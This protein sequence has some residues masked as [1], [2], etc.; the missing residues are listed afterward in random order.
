MN[1]MRKYLVLFFLL[2]VSN[3]RSAAQQT[4][5]IIPPSPDAAALGVYGS[6]P[7]STYTGV[8]N[9]NIPL[10][11][12]NY[13]D[14]HI[15]IDLSYHAAGITVEQDASWVGLGWTL[16]VGGVI[17][18]TVRGGDD[19][20]LAADNYSNL[21]MPYQGFPY[22]NQN[23]SAGGFLESVCNGN[24][25]T[26]PDMFYFNFLGRSGSFVLENGQNSS[27]GSIA[28]TPLKAE[29]IDISYDKVNLRWQIRTDDGYTFYFGTVE[30]TET[31]HG[32]GTYGAGPESVQFD[33]IN[34]GFLTFDDVVVSAWYLDKIVSP[35]GEEVN[36]I[37]DSKVN[38]ARSYYYG[39]ARLS[40][41]DTKQTIVNDN[42]GQTSPCYVPNVQTSATKTFT[43]HAYLK[44][45]TFPLGKIVFNKSLRDD[46]IP[47]TVHSGSYQYILQASSWMSF[48]QYGPQKLDNIEV[49]NNDGMVIKTFE[50]SYNYFNSQV[51]DEERYKFRRLKL[52]KVRECSGLDCNPYYQL[53][54]DESHPL[55]SKY[56]TAQ[57]FWGYYNG[58]TNNNSRIPFGTFYNGMDNKYYFLGEADRQPNS[59]YMTSGTLNKIVYPTGGSSQFEFEPHDYNHFSNDAFKSTDFTNNTTVGITGLITAEY[60]SESYKT[61]SFTLTEATQEVIIDG[62]MTY[63]A[64]A[65]TSDPCNVV[66]PGTIYVGNEPWYS[67]Q[68]TS[69]SAIIVTR[70]M[71]EFL[72]FFVSNY[73]NNCLQPPYTPDAIDPIYRNKQTFILGAGT[74]ELKLYRR[75]GFNLNVTVNKNAMPSRII[76]QNTNGI[77]GKTAGGLRIKQIITRDNLT[78]VPQVKKYDYTVP[79]QNGQKYSTGRLLLFPNY[80]VPFY[81]TTEANVLVS[82]MGRSWDNVP[83]GTS[84]SGSVVG[85]D[86]VTESMGVNGEA[87]RTEYYYQNQIEE[88]S[89]FYTYIEGF[90][91]IKKTSNG[92]IQDIKHF[93]N[94]GNPVKTENYEYSKQLQKD[95]KGLATKHLL[96]LM[97]AEGGLIP[98]DRCTNRNMVS[99]AYTIISDRWV[100]IKKTEKLYSQN[101]TNFVQTVTD[102]EYDTQTHL[103]LKSEQS[104]TS[105]GEA[106]KTVYSY[107][108]DASWIPA[109]MWQDKFVYNKVVKKE[110]L[111]NNNISS[112]YKASYSSQANTFL[113]NKEET[114]IKTFPLE[115]ANTYNYS[116]NGNVQEMISRNG[117]TQTYLWDF[118]ASL[119]IAKVTASFAN[120]AYTSFEANGNGNWTFAGVPEIDPTAPTGKK[121]YDLSGGDVIK[122]ITNTTSYIIS[123]WRPINA[124]PLSIAGTQA[125]YPVTGRTVN[126]WKYYEH[127]VNNQTAVSLSGAGLIDELRLYPLNAQMTTYTYEPLIGMTSQCDANNVITYY[128]YDA[129]GRLTLIRDQD[130]NVIRTVDYKYQNN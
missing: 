55:P 73:E 79:G 124:S 66:D 54:Y 57:D 12:I 118:N 39:S 125:G 77:Y 95:I 100:P 96:M 11:S 37:Y 34:K 104:T 80:H 27:I 17:T 111:R 46:M 8:P 99:Q 70:S 114:A 84:A 76:T 71:S 113:L 74:Y 112:T 129:F 75:Q 97:R 52:D 109:A 30:I 69:T 119:P 35:L 116:S 23:E 78:T 92:L 9:I 89:Q 4:N 85:Y 122:S 107:P 93:D 90:P 121:V 5:T 21:F 86:K 102:Y 13:R 127:K 63:Y 53:F 44:E 81:C 64:S 42:L 20:Q 68:N 60:D 47:A 117:I 14:I 87:G 130:K 82:I 67:I 22:D 24:I 25:D 1:Q 6:V 36:Y 19:M 45:I 31:L 7:V 83:L 41:A 26:E 28:G 65:T 120:I 16:N 33:P 106:M 98:N 128:E 38:D 123:Y 108:P 62:V 2:T 88:A 94:T 50:L 91:T 49:R 18:R 51:T 115:T 43:F 29:K 10:Y 40:I 58:A 15:P 101:S 59:S 105:N 3:Q 126:G 103:Q 110:I 48:S 32:L 72:N 61:V 56:S